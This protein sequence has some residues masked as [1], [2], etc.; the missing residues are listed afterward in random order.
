MQNYKLTLAFDGSAFH[1]WQR[2][3][4]ALG[5]QQVV[6]QCL[7]TLCRHTVA[8]TGCSR[9]DAGVHARHFVC[10]FYANTNIPPEKIP[11]AMNTLLP[12][13]IRVYDCTPAGDT[14]NARFDAKSKEYVYQVLNAKH[15]DPFHA[16]YAWHFPGKLDIHLM[17]KACTLLTGKHDFSAFMASGGQQKQM[18]KDM[19]SITLTRD[20][21]L[22]S[23]TYHADSYLYNM[24]RI[25]TGTI[26][27][28]GCGK[29]DC[30]DL[31]GIVQSKDRTLAGM[32][33]PPQGLFLHKAHYK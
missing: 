32:T 23:L 26:V 12:R 29:I 24:V 20:G 28:V 25:L 1:G 2:Q 17:E 9:T 5:I 30:N 8:V 19:Q 21:N 33:A 4:N 10:N 7:S 27:Y 31:P 22:I 15:N 18:K 13:Q 14:F 6:E 3:E 11:F 16:N